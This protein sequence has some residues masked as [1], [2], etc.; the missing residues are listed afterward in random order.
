MSR[1]REDV[2]IAHSPII[3]RKSR[4]WVCVLSM[5][6]NLEKHQSKTKPCGERIH[7]ALDSSSTAGRC[8]LPAVLVLLASILRWHASNDCSQLWVPS[9]AFRLEQQGMLAPL[10]HLFPTCNYTLSSLQDIP[11]STY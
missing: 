3:T 11:E 5:S 1:G 4:V 10:G 2:S 8:L 7:K 9:V 6:G